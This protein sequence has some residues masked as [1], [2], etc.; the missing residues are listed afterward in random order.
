MVPCDK[1]GGFTEVRE[2]GMTL[3]DYFAGQAL[4]GL[5]GR[6]AFD[7]SAEDMLMKQGIKPEQIDDFM[8][9]LAYDFADAMIA[10]RKS[11]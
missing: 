5:V 8:A 1:D 6:A 2:Q 3:R 7:Q 11:P 4:S 9:M 10:N